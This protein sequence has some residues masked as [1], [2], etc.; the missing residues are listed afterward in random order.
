MPLELPLIDAKA[1]TAGIVPPSIAFRIVDSDGNEVPQGMAGELLLKGDNVFSTY[2]RQPEA[3]K[4]AF[5]EDGWF[6]TG[7]I[8]RQDE[9]GFLSLVDRKK[10]MFI[11]G[12]ENVYPVEIESLLAGLPGIKEAAMVGVPDAKWGE[13]GHLAVVVAENGPTESEILLYLS[14]R[15]AKYKIP[16]YISFTEAL[17]RTGTGKIQKNV[18]K[19]SLR[20]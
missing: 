13:V 7:D 1:S 3:T 18:L 9:D 6:K 4:A 20:G 12:G 19:Q 11:S 16:K 14:A 5:T 8:A 15:L 10:D 2:W 17:P